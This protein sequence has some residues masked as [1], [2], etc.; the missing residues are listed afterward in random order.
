MKRKLPSVTLAAIVVLAGGCQPAE[1]PPDIAKSQ[2]DA[3]GKAKA[4][5]GVLQQ[6]AQ[7]HRQAADEASK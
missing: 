5:E 1:S 3:L 2:R 7:E 6:Q 4:V